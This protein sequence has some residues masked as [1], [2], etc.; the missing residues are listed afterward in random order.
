MPLIRKYR[1]A[2]IFTL[3]TN[4]VLVFTI[5]VYRGIC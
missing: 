2:Q 3:L 4:N 1:I 5:F